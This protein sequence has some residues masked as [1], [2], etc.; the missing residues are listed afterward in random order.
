MIYEL[1]VYGK[2]ITQGS[3]IPFRRKNGSLGVRD[4]SSTSLTIWRKNITDTAKNS[5][6]KPSSPISGAV[7]VHATFYIDK[8]LSN[9]HDYPVTRNTTG[10][11]DK[12]VRALFDSITNAG[13]WDDDV[14]VVSMNICKEWST[15][16]HKQG[17]HCI[18]AT[19]EE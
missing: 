9:K 11:L 3:K 8:A 1:I 14:Q 4:Q 7:D 5:D 12:L 6:S 13:W 15:E 18:I 17:V 10:D 2:P 16:W 19:I